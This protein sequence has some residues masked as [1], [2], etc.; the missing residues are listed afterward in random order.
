MEWDET[1]AFESKARLH[2]I[3]RNY[4]KAA[5]GMGSKIYQ[6]R[7]EFILKS[8]SIRNSGPLSAI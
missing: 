5:A 6:L 4:S 3:S 1:A 2:F 8:L 7:K